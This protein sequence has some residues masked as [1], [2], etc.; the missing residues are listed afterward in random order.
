MRLPSTPETGSELPE[1]AGAPSPQ[2]RRPLRVL[3]VDDNVD[4]ALL[5]S[6][7][8]RLEGH[9]VVVAHDGAAALE[10]RASFVPD[11]ALLDIGLPVMDGYELARTL[12][13][14][15]PV[16][17]TRLI[18]VTGY[19][20]ARDR[21]LSREAGFDEHLVKPVDV[22]RMCRLLSPRPAASAGPREP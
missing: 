6:E 3:L 9:E 5:L 10:A 4:A 22:E 19:G 21:A 16:P 7:V 12:R 8:L 2:G 1:Q 11:V 14:R 13:A 15:Y 20:E 18:A 17:R